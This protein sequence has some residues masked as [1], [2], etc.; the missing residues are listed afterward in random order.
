[1][2][3]TKLGDEWPDEARDLSDAAYRT[4]VDALTWS[5]RRGLDLLVPKR[6]IK[7][8]A[9]TADPDTAIKEL[10]H[11]GWWEDRGDA[12]FLGLRFADWQLER[13]VVDQRREAT[14][15]RVRRHRL[16]EAADHSICLPKNCAQARTEASRN[17]SPN[18]LRNALPGTGR[19]GAVRGGHG[20]ALPSP[21]PDQKKG[22]EGGPG[23]EE[24]AYPEQCS[25]HQDGEHGDPCTPCGRART[26]HRER[27]A[28]QQAARAREE[29]LRPV[30]TCPVHLLPAPCRGCAADAKA[31]A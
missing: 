8:F 31:A 27:Q 1:M 5:N 11:T 14:A 16:H 20:E 19:D 15:L 7:R 25:R 4:H 17:A 10:E 22:G 3:W 28:T 12:W 30:Q 6:D 21:H 13:R 9:E 18:A 23:G 24:P 26:A 29:A 2:T